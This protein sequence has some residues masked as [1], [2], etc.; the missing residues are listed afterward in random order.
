MFGSPSLV[1]V[2]Q[3]VCED[4]EDC[5]RVGLAGNPDLAEFHTNADVDNL[6]DSHD[7]D[8]VMSD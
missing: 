6:N 2:E 8:L 5:V 3:Q 7:V 1:P 4:C